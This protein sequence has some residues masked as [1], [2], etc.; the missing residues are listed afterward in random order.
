MAFILYV[1]AFV[2]TP[3]PA[4]AFFG[5][6]AQTKCKEQAQ[7]AASQGNH[8]LII[9]M[10][11]LFGGRNGR[12]AAFA[13]RALG[14]AGKSATVMPYSHTQS[15]AAAECAAIWKSIHGNRLKVT[16][17]GHSF[18]GG[19]GAFPTLE[20]MAEKGIRVQ[21][22]VVFDG[23]TGSEMVCGELG[24]P[25]FT[26]PPNVDYVTNFY[27]CGAGLPGRTFVEDGRVR[28]HRLPEGFG[29]HVNLPSN[30]FALDVVSDIFAHRLPDSTGYAPV[31]LQAQK[32]SGFQM[33][34]VPSIPPK[35]SRN[36][37]AICFRFGASYPC[38]YEEASRQNSSDST[39]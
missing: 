4:K 22:L 3:S 19:R 23:R 27:Q 17:V 31:T 12:A 34:A 36:R 29:A 26:R 38:T 2:L 16:F 6:S 5:A 28:N 21:D 24:G 39:R 32:T 13:R 14:R 18:G 35:S 33:R 7:Q 30:S 8:S 25:K 11:G 20:K 37:M 1:L 9:T 10:E 15:S